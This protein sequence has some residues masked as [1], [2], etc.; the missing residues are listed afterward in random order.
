MFDDFYFIDLVFV[1]LVLCWPKLIL[2]FLLL[3]LLFSQ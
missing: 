2:F 1:V 3:E